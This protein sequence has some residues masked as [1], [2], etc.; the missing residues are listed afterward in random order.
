MLAKFEITNFKSFHDTFVFDLSDPSAYNFNETCITNKLVGKALIYGPNGSGKSNLGFAIFDVISHLTD[1]NSDSRYYASNYLNADS[2]SELA[3]FTYV[4]RF[5]TDE[6]VYT[7]TKQDYQ[8]LISERLQINGHLYAAIDRWHSHVFQTTAKGAETLKKDLGDSQISIINYLSN[9]ALL[10]QDDPANVLFSRFRQFVNSMLYFRSVDDRCYIGFEQ[11]SDLISH[12]IVSRGNIED[13]ETFLND[14]GVQCTLRS[15]RVN[16]SNEIFFAFEHHDIEFYE[17]ASSGTKALALFYF[18]YQR[19]KE[20]KGVRF[21]FIDEFDAF[22]HHAVSRLI[23][24]KLKEATGVQVILTTHN[25][26]IIS[27]DLLRPDCYFIMDA[28]SIKP[29]S[30]CTQKELRQAHN[31][32]K[33]YRA[34]SFG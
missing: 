4:F 33:M 9:N 24:E 19:I 10:D 30:K 29:I 5:D 21:V 18:W 25:T 23:V 20:D 34:G 7:Y 22:Y 8:T 27:N 12:D 13:F 6:V 11:G 15:K 1:K 14:A 26:S 2:D 3:T 16:D 31:I 32:E 17:I 28:T